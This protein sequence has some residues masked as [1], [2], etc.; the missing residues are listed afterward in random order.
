[1]GNKHP[2]DDYLPG[3]AGL[4]QLQQLQLLQDYTAF[5]PEFRLPL[6]QFLYSPS[7]TAMLNRRADFRNQM[8]SLGTRDDLLKSWTGDGH[9]SLLIVS[10]VFTGEGLEDDLEKIRSLLA[11]SM[12]VYIVLLLFPGPDIVSEQLNDISDHPNVTIRPLPVFPDISRENRLLLQPEAN[13]SRYFPGPGIAV[14]SVLADESLKKSLPPL[15]QDDA[16]LWYCPVGLAEDC[17]SLPPEA[18]IVWMR[19]NTQAITLLALRQNSG[20]LKLKP[21]GAFRLKEGV[22]QLG[23]GGLENSGVIAERILTVNRLDQLDDI[24]YQEVRRV[25]S[26]LSDIAL[27][28]HDVT[29]AWFE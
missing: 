26:S 3:I 16:I 11:D 6:V 15:A 14:Q 5:R 21:A 28:S 22:C 27:H 4:P 29:I 7:G 10:P 8:I 13:I 24:N 20:L 18:L 25:R 17:F 12:N 9:S 19:A 1:S 23:V 2:V